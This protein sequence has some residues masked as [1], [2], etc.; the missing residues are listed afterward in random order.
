M[1]VKRTLIVAFGVAIILTFIVGTFSVIMYQ[2]ATPTP[3]PAP[4]AGQ[5]AGAAEADAKIVELQKSLFFDCNATGTDPA[6][7]AKQVPEITLAYRA[8]QTGYTA[9]LSANASNATVEQLQTALSAVCNP[10]ILWSAK[11][12]FSGKVTLSDLNDVNA[13]HDLYPITLNQ[14]PGLV[15][16]EGAWAGKTVRVLVY[17][18]MDGDQITRLM[19]EEAQKITPEATPSTT[20]QASINASMNGT[21]ANETQANAS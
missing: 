16:A 5:F 3:T 7:L 8:S 9:M 18:E 12:E 20:P 21:A 15:Y 2:R 19:I 13:T 1:N 11:L 17:A 14:Q 10:I 6:A 4:A